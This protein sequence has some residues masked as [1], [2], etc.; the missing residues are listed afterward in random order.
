MKVRI[1]KYALSVVVF[2]LLLLALV[3]VDERVRDRFEDVI[4]G[5]TDMSPLDD[6]L[7]DLGDAVG[8]ALRTQSVE[9]GPLVA[10]ATVGAVLF[11]FMFRT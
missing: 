11:L 4:A 1:R 2:G 10:F 5:R 7:A 6:R 9:N 8:L 3:W